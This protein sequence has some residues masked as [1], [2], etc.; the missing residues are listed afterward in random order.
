M[1]LGL[2][3]CPSKLH[4]ITF[5]ERAIYQEARRILCGYV[6]RCCHTRCAC[7]LKALQ[8]QQRVFVVGLLAGMYFRIVIIKVLGKKKTFFFSFNFGAIYTVLNTC[9]GRIE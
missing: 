6:K 8:S 3:L 1:S 2:Y 5:S 9:F 4:F 7:M